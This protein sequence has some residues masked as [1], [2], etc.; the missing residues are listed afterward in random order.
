MSIKEPIMQIIFYKNFFRYIGYP[1]YNFWVGRST[2]SVLKEREK[3]QHFS[4][5]KLADLQ[6]EKLKKVLINAKKHVPYYREQFTQLGFNPESLQ[7]LEEFKKLN[8]YISKSEVKANTENFIAENCNSKKLH[9][10]RTGG[11]TGEPLL[12]ATDPVTDSA[13]NASLIRNLH[14]W[15]VDIGDPH[16]MFWGSPT[17]I[18]RKPSD[19]LKQYALALKHKLM[20]RLF[21]SNYDLNPKNMN[22]Y[23]KKIEKF[24]PSY[25][26]GMPSS[27]YTFALYLVENDMALDRGRPVMVHS[28]C[29][30]LFDWQKTVI[31]KGF[32]APVANTYGLSELGDI[33]FEGPERDLLIMDE[34]V[35][36][37]LLPNED[38]T[39]EIVATQL[40]NL[41]SPLI[42][43]RTGDIANS[44]T[45]NTQ[46]DKGLRILRGLQGRAHDFIKTADG[47]VIH[48][49]FFTHV[50]VFE[51]GIK[52]YQIVQKTLNDIHIRIVKEQ[53]YSEQSEKPIESAIQ[54]YLGGNVNVSFEY[55]QKIELTPRGKYRWIISEVQVS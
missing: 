19:K 34:D 18:V 55:V 6:L 48:G 30:Q 37:E 50:I 49:Q 46:T 13:S 47:K 12:F 39:N 29:E 5:K 42:R 20:N 14:W 7:S 17:F 36:I 3:S 11:S 21:I 38:G 1:L 16:V 41:L 9:W 53:N 31:E 24:K 54:S 23:R 27:L 8:F 26:R 43:Y 2:F 52:N 45:N 40:N 4:S 25:I 44:I 51:P 33:A 32:G 35:L 15:G 10:H 22:E 28:A